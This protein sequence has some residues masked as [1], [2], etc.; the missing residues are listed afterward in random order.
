M[1]KQDANH[2]KINRLL[3]ALSVFIVVPSIF[4]AATLVQDSIIRT[5]INN[6]IEEEFSDA[7][8]I[9]QDY[10][11][12]DDLLLVTTTGKR[13]TEEELAE[14]GSRLPDYG[15]RTI[16]LSVTQVPDLN[17]LSGEKVAELL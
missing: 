13:L 11:E 16:E 2:K 5:G 17:G 9:S 12:D 3:I 8:I 7:I 6:F 14:I 10:Q 15:L 1:T 4:S